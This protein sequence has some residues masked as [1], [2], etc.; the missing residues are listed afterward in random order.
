MKT[1]AL[2]LIAGFIFLSGCRD[3]DDA[4]QELSERVGALDSRVQELEASNRAAGTEIA[5]LQ[6]A[7][8][9]VPATA[10]QPPAA[11]IELPPQAAPAVAANSALLARIESLV[12]ARVTE[13]VASALDARLG[14]KQD[15]E[16]VF[17]DVV[18][19]EIT[20]LE[21]RKRKAEEEQR[22]R[23][24]EEYEERRQ[25][26]EEQ[27][28]AALSEEL[29]LSEQQQAR[30]REITQNT[31]TIMQATFAQMR[32]DGI[33]GREDFRKVV[34]EVVAETETAMQGVLTEEQYKAYQESENRPRSFLFGRRDGRRSP[35][36][37]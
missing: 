22:Q 1:M 4:L 9:E 31:R 37:D 13:A 24:R 12:S 11:S 2:A 32:E 21:E 29:Q 36:A 33:F 27:R 25:E 16:A 23:R 26:R 7:A 17:E 15:I 34:A 6:K 30:M 10:A 20:A 18:Q 19:E 28:L 14:T 35:R 5:R 3:D 8:A